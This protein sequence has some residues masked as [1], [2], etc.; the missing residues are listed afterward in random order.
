MPFASSVGCDISDGHAINMHKPNET[1]RIPDAVGGGFD[2][3]NCK[4]KNISSSLNLE[5]KH[6]N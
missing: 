3:T 2:V 5:T 4:I 1:K 6:K